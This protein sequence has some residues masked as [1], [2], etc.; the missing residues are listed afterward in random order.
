MLI[1]WWKARRRKIHNLS[2]INK[3][4]NALF[5]IAKYVAY[6][7]VKQSSI[8]KYVA[9]ALH[10]KMGTELKKLDKKFIFNIIQPLFS[11]FT[12][13]FRQNHLKK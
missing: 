6:K 3:R 8:A 1:R 9:F 13:S 5:F 12:A 11:P 4:A 2:S 10:K 7:L